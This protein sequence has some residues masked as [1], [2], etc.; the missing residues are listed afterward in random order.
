[1]SQKSNL[2]WAFPIIAAFFL[3][4]QAYQ[5]FTR[6]SD[7]E[8]AEFRVLYAGARD[9][10]DAFSRCQF[11]VG[12]PIDAERLDVQIELQKKFSALRSK[13]SDSRFSSDQKLLDL[14][15]Q[16]KNQNPQTEMEDDA[17]RCTRLSP[18]ASAD[19]KEVSASLSDV[20]NFLEKY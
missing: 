12:K 18:F 5:I 16:L 15:I 13:I 14:E 20:E 2:V 8:R 11:A 9:R 7:I 6:V 3:G 17:V 1:V 4:W 10:L 19:K